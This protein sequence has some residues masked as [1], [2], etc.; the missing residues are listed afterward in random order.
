MC[1][2]DDLLMTEEVISR[3]GL[4]VENL[5]VSF[6]GQAILG[7][8]SFSVSAGECCSI[9]GANGVGKTTLLRAIVGVVDSSGRIAVGGCEL[10]GLSS[11]RRAQLV[12][13]V[14]QQNRSDIELTVKQFLE[15]ASYPQSKRP[16]GF[17]LSEVLDDLGLGLLFENRLCEL[18]GGEQRRV[19]L[20]A[21]LLQNTELILL[22]EP[23]SS[24][25]PFHLV[26]SFRRVV[27]LAKE[28]GVTVLT[29]M[30][31]LPLAWAI[32]DRVI[33]MVDNRV[34]VEGTPDEL[35]EGDSLALAFGEE[36]GFVTGPEGRK[37]PLPAGL[38]RSLGME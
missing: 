35:L 12:S 8:I 30:H 14:P 28:R 18:S 5:S 13:Y 32:S 33:V 34:L 26:T 7:R 10:N 36:V 37:L 3:E 15:L 31:D 2:H 25:D 24:L 19:F 27:Q 6:A 1:A 4:R 38:L 17:A 11:R 22:D 16:G 9:I 20:A 23:T 29:V 21:S